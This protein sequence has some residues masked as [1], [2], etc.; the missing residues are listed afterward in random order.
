MATCSGRRGLPRWS[1][2]SWP[3]GGARGQMGIK[4]PLRSSPPP[5]VRVI[6]ALHGDLLATPGVTTMVRG[7]LAHRRV[8]EPDGYKATA[9]IVAA[10]AAAWR[11]PVTTASVPACGK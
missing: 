5:D 4:P 1:V 3:T 7:F 11:M 8:P 2:V 10:A 9:E 6:P